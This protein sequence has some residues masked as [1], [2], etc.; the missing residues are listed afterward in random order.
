MKKL[1]IIL[2]LAIGSF[3]QAQAQKFAHANF[4]EIITMLPER[5]EAEKKVQDLQKKLEARLQSMI[6]TYQNKMQEFENDPDMSDAMKTSAA[7]EIQDLQRRIQE[8]QQTAYQEIETKQNELMA[9]MFKRVREA[10]VK[11]GTDNTYTYIFDS[12][13]QGGLLYAGGEDITGLIK[14]ELGI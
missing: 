11:V 6:E 13:T 3:S 5:A 12:S 14:K 1:L 9:G 2:A 8:F 7:G 4:E 10:S